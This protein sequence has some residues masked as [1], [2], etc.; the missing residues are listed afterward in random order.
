MR[1]WW[2][3]ATCVLPFIVWLGCAPARVA[4]M[5][6]GGDGQGRPSLDFTSVPPWGSTFGPLVGVLH[7]VSNPA[8][9]RVAVFIY[10]GAGWWNKPRWD[11]PLTPLIV[12]QDGDVVFITNIVTG[13]IDEQA[14]RIAAYLVPDGVTPP[15][16]AGA[17]T[18]PNDFTAEA[19]ASAEAARTPIVLSV[20]F[21]GRQ[22]WVKQSAGLV[23]PGPSLYSPDPQDVFVDDTGQ[24]HLRIAHRDGR[25]TAAEVVL[26]DSL[27][28][29]TYAFTTTSRVDLLDQN[30]VLGLFNWADDPAQ[31]HRE[32]DVEYSRWG[33]PAAPQNAQFVVQ[34]FTASNHRHQFPIDF[35]GAPAVTH[36]FVWRPGMVAFRLTDSSNKVLHEWT[37][38]G[39]DVPTPGSETPR[40]NLWMF[41]GAPPKDGQEVEVTIQ[42]FTFTPAE[43]GSTASVFTAAG[44]LLP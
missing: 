13:G 33:D 2:M 9:Y 15:R 20:Q 1:R 36:S 41:G 6:A 16:L 38:A 19:V 22:W 10:V 29:G 4:G 11:A 30:V 26:P 23:D 3:L 43:A 18:I 21:A 25:W 34:P 28:Y 40:V 35:A 31:S 8:D 14:T 12:N 17:P 42:S 44:P 37:Y 39:P 32:L 7:G 5:Q 24:L 27:G